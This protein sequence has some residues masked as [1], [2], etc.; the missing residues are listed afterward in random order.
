MTIT[1]HIDLLPI[2]S[3]YCSDVN[4]IEQQITGQ[5]ILIEFD[6]TPDLIEKMIEAAKMHGYLQAIK[7]TQK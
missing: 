1:V 7:Q 4:L 3:K 5:Y 2:L 6:P